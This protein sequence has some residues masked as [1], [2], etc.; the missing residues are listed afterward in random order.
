VETIAHLRDNGRITIML[1]AFEGPP[2]IVR[3]YGTGRVVVRDTDEYAALAP[4]FPDVP[5]ARGVIVVD[6]ERV[7]DS[8]GYGV[9]VLRY[10]EDRQRL[11]EWA[12]HK[13]DDGLVRYRAEHNATSID[14]LAGLPGLAPLE[15][16][17]R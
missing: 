17:A 2:R 9:P 10:V 11:V 12:E 16:D 5:G 1:C 7:A 6:V 13:G 3:I 14:G 4:H 15:P 8:C